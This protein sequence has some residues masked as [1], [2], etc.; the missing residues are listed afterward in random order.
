MRHSR[1]AS[2]SCARPSAAMRSQLFRRPRSIKSRA[3][4]PHHHARPCIGGVAVIGM[5]GVP[6]RR[7]GGTAPDGSGA[8]LCAAVRVVHPGWNR[9]R[10]RSRCAG[11]CR[12]RH[13]GTAAGLDIQTSPK[14]VIDELPFAAV[15]AGGKGKVIRPPRIVLATDQ[16]EALRERLIAELSDLKS[17]DEAAHWVHKNLPAK[18]TLALADAETVEAEL[19]RAHIA[20][21]ISIR[22]GLV[23]GSRPGPPSRSQSRRRH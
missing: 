15:G 23:S 8:H 22:P 12:R 7:D 17:A 13:S 6:N 10:G 4:P 18:N 9:R 5:A 16:S 1:P 3:D 21:P 20:K 19:S 11:P 14:P 2:T